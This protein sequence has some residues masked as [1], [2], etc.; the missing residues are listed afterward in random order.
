MRVVL[1]INYYRDSDPARRAELNEALRLN[2]ECSAI[3]HVYVLANDL[4]PWDELGVDPAISVGEKVTESLWT[5]RPTFADLFAEAN[6]AIQQG[7]GEDDIGIVVN[8]DVYFDQGLDVVR[9]IDLTGRCLALTRWNVLP[10][11][12]SELHRHGYGWSQD[13]WIFRGTV[14]CMESATFNL[15]LNRCDNRIAQLLSQA[16]YELLNPCLSPEFK[17]CHLHASAVR[18]ESADWSQRVD[19]P[20][21][22]VVPQ[23]LEDMP[24]VPPPVVQ[25]IQLAAAGDILNVLPI[26]Q[27]LRSQYFTVRM[28]VRPEYAPLLEGVGYVEPWVFD[29]SR[30]DVAGAILATEHLPAAR[31]L[32]TQVDCNPEP[33]C[34]AETFIH[35]QWMR[36]GMGDAWG[37]LPLEFDRRDRVREAA[38]VASLLDADDGRPVLLTNFMAQSAPYAPGPLIAAWL[39]HRWGETFQIVDLSEVRAERLYDLLG[40]YERADVL[41]TVDTATLHLAYAT[42]TP[43]IAIVNDKPFLAPP[44]RP[45]WIERLSYTESATRAGVARIDAAIEQMLEWREM[46]GRPRKAKPRLVSTPWAPI[47]SP[48]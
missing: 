2:V 5:R 1:V 14:R 7:G 46:G 30:H 39:A 44:S 28:V 20:I 15:G 35:E 19:G 16:G 37:T 21:V 12:T 33:C 3:D 29:G 25:I 9:S 34:G 8:G 45:H 47:E 32:V 43:T 26:A 38:L 22:P 6:R 13:S 48:A 23:R 31:R 4:V 17:T 41:L 11:G 40:V 18:R 27:Y 10:D 36:A 24:R 42:G